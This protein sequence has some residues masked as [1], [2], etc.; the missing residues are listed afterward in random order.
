MH[1]KL[2]NKI[3]KKD[4]STSYNDLIHLDTSS[5]KQVCFKNVFVETCSQKVAMDNEKQ[6][7]EVA[8]L[9]KY[10]IQVNDKTKSIDHIK[11]TPW[12]SEEAL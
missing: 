10:L 5:C 12:R 11:I 2:K 8:R 6:K 9:T 1:L 7:Q 3:V 4:V